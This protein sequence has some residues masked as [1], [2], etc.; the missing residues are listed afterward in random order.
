MKKLIYSLFTI[1]AFFGC[2]EKYISPVI[3]PTTGYLVVDGTINAS[4]GNT[5]LI[6]KRT[7]ALDNPIVVYETSAIVSVIGEDNS[8]FALKENS[9]GHYV[10]TNLNLNKTKKYKLHIQT[11]DTKVYESDLVEVRTTPAID[12]LSYKY[13]NSGLQIF[14]NTHDATGNTKYYQWDYTETWEYHSPFLNYFNYQQLN[15]SSGVKYT[16][17]YF[18]PILITYNSAIYK[19]WP[20]ENSSSILLGST[21]A[22]TSDKIYLPINYISKGDVKLSELYSINARQYSLSEGRYNYLQKMKK[23]T[24]GTGSV[25]DAQ[26]SELTGNIHC[27]TNASEPVIG[28]VD[29]CNTQTARIFIKNAQ[30]P[31]W[32]YVTP[33]LKTEIPNNVDSI[34]LAHRN[35]YPAYAAKYSPTGSAILSYYFSTPSCVDCTFWGTNI[36]PTFW[37]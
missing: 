7:V 18:D 20:T 13:D 8:I 31:D 2:K 35:L 14:V 36:K 19:C 15:T 34:T 16:L 21:V 1:L 30:V 27:T 5:E 25:F 28:Y 4:A 10:A 26:P 24:E 29:I 37:P 3:S 12:S 17:I 6:L 9:T 32:N 22:L 33:C 23:N 11:K